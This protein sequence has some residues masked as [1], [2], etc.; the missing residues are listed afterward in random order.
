MLFSESFENSG[1]TQL[2]RFRQAVDEKAKYWA[3][4]LGLTPILATS[5]A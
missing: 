2:E 3:T 5:N 1:T 4:G